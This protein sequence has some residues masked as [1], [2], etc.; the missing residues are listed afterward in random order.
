M[1]ITRDKRLKNSFKIRK[2][3]TLWE[4]HCMMAIFL[5]IFSVPKYK[6]RQFYKISS[7][8][9]DA[10]LANLKLKKGGEEFEPV[11]LKVWFL[12]LTEPIDD[13]ARKKASC[14]RVMIYSQQRN[15]LWKPNKKYLKQNGKGN[16]PW[17]ADPLSED[18]IK[19]LYDTGVLE[20]TS[21]QSLLNTVWFNNT[22]NLGL[23]GHRE[24]Y[25]FCWGDISFQ[26]TL[27]MQNICIID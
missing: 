3:K 14:N 6:M 23:G 9:I 5:V 13:T 17:K 4:K 22:I 11:S 20:V 15:K 27:M 21:N 2:T 10:F 18:Y 16:R 7:T 1:F 24:H 8:E 25:N 12:V 19:I 26:I